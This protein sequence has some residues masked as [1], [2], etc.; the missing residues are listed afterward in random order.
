MSKHNLWV[1]CE[2]HKRSVKFLNV[3]LLKNQEIKGHSQDVDKLHEKIRT[4]KTT[5]AKFCQ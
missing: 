3:K 2:E 5:L 1:E 4:L